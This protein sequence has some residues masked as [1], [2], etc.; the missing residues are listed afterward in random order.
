MLV[1]IHRRPLS[2]EEEGGANLQ[3]IYYSL[4]HLRDRFLVAN[5]HAMLTEYCARDDAHRAVKRFQLSKVSH[6]CVLLLENPL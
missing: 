4:K 6:Y 2:R 3:L 1:T 5:G